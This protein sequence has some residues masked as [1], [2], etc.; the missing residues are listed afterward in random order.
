MYLVSVIHTNL[1][2][3]LMRIKGLVVVIVRRAIFSSTILNLECAFP[4]K[5]F[6]VVDVYDMR[7]SIHTYVLFFFLIL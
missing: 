7:M 5:A 6:G 1:M 2:P 3:I 4:E